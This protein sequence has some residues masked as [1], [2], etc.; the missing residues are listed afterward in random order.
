MVSSKKRKIKQNAIWRHIL[1]VI[2]GLLLGI[3]IYL[4]NANNLLGNKL[5]MPFGYGAAVVLSG[6]MEPTFSKDDLIIVKKK[7]SFDIGDVVVYQSNDSLVVHRVVSMDGDMV[8]T[9]GDANNIEDA[10]FDKI[11]IKGVVIGCIPSLGV[12]VN[13]IKTPTGT[14]VVLLCAFLLIE[15]SFRKQKASD[16]KRIED[17]KAEIRRLREEKED[18]DEKYK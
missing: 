15:L 11:A 14:I 5:P 3:N 10:S 17:I 9:K 8:V 1:L 4:V 7:D 16:D 12:F 2:C 6:S 18:Y 13:A